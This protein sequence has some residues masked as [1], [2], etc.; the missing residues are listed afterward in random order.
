MSYLSILP[1]SR[2]SP[3]GEGGHFPHGGNKKGG[4]NN[5]TYMFVI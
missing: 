1:P 5:N 3:M 2:P 4:K